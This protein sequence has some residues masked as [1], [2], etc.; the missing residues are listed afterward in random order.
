MHRSLQRIHPLNRVTHR[1][2]RWDQARGGRR[3]VD[4]TVAVNRQAHRHAVNG[5][6]GFKRLLHPPDRHRP[7]VG[8]RAFNV[9][10][11]IKQQSGTWR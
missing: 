7:G 8:E 2:E 11:A 3:A 5:R 9:Q 4:Q 10:K 1:L 6:V